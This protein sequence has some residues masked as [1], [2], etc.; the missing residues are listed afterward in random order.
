MGGTP[1]SYPRKED[2]CRS[3][4]TSR[5]G[6][7]V[8][9]DHSSHKLLD[10]VINGDLMLRTIPL[11]I[12]R[13]FFENVTPREFLPEFIELICTHSGPYQTGQTHYSN[14]T[15][16]VSTPVI[17]CD[18]KKDLLRGLKITNDLDT[19]G[20]QCM[21]LLSLHLECLESSPSLFDVDQSPLILRVPMWSDT[22]AFVREDKLAWEPWEWT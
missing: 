12:L 14:I 8:L 22:F 18:I 2:R 11:K 10:E 15:S 17:L 21:H 4:T 19:K 5:S 7:L 9:R 3:E 1:P 16:G 6:T 20:S 13:K